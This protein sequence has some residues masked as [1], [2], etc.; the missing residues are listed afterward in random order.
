LF[1]GSTKL[2]AGVLAFLSLTGASSP[3]AAAAEQALWLDNLDQA[4]KKAIDT[5]K[6]ILVYFSGSDWCRPCKP[7]FS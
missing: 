7:G 3:A 4:S 2:V 5:K 6:P 1:K